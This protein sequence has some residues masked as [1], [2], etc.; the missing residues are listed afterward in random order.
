MFLTIIMQQLFEK[1]EFNSFQIIKRYF[2]SKNNNIEDDVEDRRSS[3][4]TDNDY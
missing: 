4:R 2:K 1:A 3:R